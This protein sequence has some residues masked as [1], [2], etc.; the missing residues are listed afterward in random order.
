M[1]EVANKINEFVVNCECN[2]S[3]A[4]MLRKNVDEQL[5]VK[6]SPKI[7]YYVTDL[8]DPCQTYWKQVRPDVKRPKEL[9]RKL[10]RGTQLHKNA[11]YWLSTFEEFSVYEGKIDGIYVDLP[12]V[13]GSI[14]YL[15]GK[16]IVDLKTKDKV[17]DTPEDVLNNYP[18][19]VEQ[20]SFYSAIHPENPL[21]NY[22]LFM[23]N[24]HPFK[25][26]AFK[27]KIK[28]LGRIKSLILDRIKKLNFAFENKNP[29]ALGRSRYHNKTCYLCE[30][31]LCNCEEL[32]PLSKLVE[33]KEK[34]K[35]PLNV[36]TIWNLLAPVECYNELVLGVKPP[37]YNSDEKDEYTLCLRNLVEQLPFKVNLNDKQGI[38]SSLKEPRLYLGF[39]WLKINTSANPSGTFIPYLIKVSNSAETRTAI[40]PNSFHLAQLG[41]FAA[42][43]GKSKGILFVVYPK[44]N[45]LIQAYEVSY[46]NTP[47]MLKY[48]KKLIDNL[49]K[50]I[51]DKDGSNL[52]PN[53]PFIKTEI[54]TQLP[55]VQ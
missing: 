44:L 43:Y 18:Q 15:L 21:E 10:F 46:Q 22:I 35:A 49:E 4:A 37:P 32:A 8:C 38:K 31:K 16:K 40:K 2:E 1:E 34:I 6:S 52:P 39:K 36:F 17:P 29:S 20:I 30:E 7:Y 27:I 14:D 53:P 3:I 48:I 13:R 47:D 26:K 51:K 41:I 42:A 19:D 33:I 45:D 23:E 11:S 9:L 25:L 54:Q 55:E 50:S 28:D 24:S 12:G 5:K